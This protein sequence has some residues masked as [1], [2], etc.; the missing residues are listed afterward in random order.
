LKEGGRLLALFSFAAINKETGLEAILAKW[1]VQV[2]RNVI[3]D[4]DNTTSGSDVVAGDFSNKHPLVNPLLRSRL[5]LILPRSVGQARLLNP[6]PDAPN[7]EEIVFSGPRAQAWVDNNPAGKPQRFPLMVAVEKGAIKDVITE[8][9]TT[10]MVVAG[11]S[12]FLVNRQIDSADNRAF[13]GYAVN[14]LLERTQLVQGPGPRP[15]K[16]YTL[17]MTKSQLQSAQWIL[18]GGLPGAVLLLGGLVWL[19]RRR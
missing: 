6:A 1:G 17:V 8:R 10:R 18:L 15:V 4:P 11:D 13:A 12:I 5:Q 9:G 19:R 3:K 7:V 2:G 14:W 16:E